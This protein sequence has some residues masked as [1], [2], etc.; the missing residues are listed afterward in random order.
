MTGGNPPRPRVQVQ[1]I[2]Q[3]DP[4]PV[5]FYYDYA[6]APSM[7]KSFSHPTLIYNT[8][9]RTLRIPTTGASAEF[10]GRERA[11]DGLLWRFPDGGAIGHG[12]R[13]SSG[14]GAREAIAPASAGSGGRLPSI[15][16]TPHRC[17]SPTSLYTANPASAPLAT[18][19][20]YRESL[21]AHTSVGGLAPYGITSP[22][23][24]TCRFGSLG[25]ALDVTR[26]PDT[27]RLVS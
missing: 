1:S 16:P 14:V 7:L 21:P 24:L 23:R 2:L 25:S 15:L 10:I 19:M 22:A 8:P 12:G 9:S 18:G 27:H 11:Q 6:N 13:R 5:R 20:Y 4:H 17:R 26:S 3:I